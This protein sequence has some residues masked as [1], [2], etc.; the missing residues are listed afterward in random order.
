MPTPLYGDIFQYLDPNTEGAKSTW[1]K[2]VQGTTN[3]LETDANGNQVLVWDKAIEPDN[4]MIPDK[5]KGLVTGTYST[6]GGGGGLNARYDTS[7]LPNQGKLANGRNITDMVSLGLDRN[8]G[9]KTI[10]RG[11]EFGGRDQDT[12]MVADKS[13]MLWDD[14]FGWVNPKM[15][16]KHPIEEKLSPVDYAGMALGAGMGAFASPVMAAA[17]AG[18]NGLHAFGDASLNGG[19][20]NWGQLA[21]QI[22]PS[23]IGMGGFK[24]PPE[25]ANLMKYLN[26][27]KMGYGGYN[28]IKNGNPYQI[29]QT[30]LG[31][32][33]KG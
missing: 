3:H 30:A 25:L 16:F 13:Q 18:M 32:I 8:A 19:K 10:T 6:A 1:A 5:Y 11:S 14:N 4:S 17:M 24:L 33:P 21:L 7:K 12:S 20:M 31:F 15:N 23:L 2:Q 22:A 28:A 29:A 27:A 26:Y 9:P